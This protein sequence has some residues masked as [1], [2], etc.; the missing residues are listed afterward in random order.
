[1]EVAYLLAGEEL[2]PVV[3]GYPTALCAIGWMLGAPLA[4]NVEFL[5]A[6][7]FCEF[8][9]IEIRENFLHVNILES[10]GLILK[11]RTPAFQKFAKFYCMQIVCPSNSQKFPVANFS[12]STI[13]KIAFF[14]I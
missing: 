6:G 9:E 14:V 12:S 11:L 5:H 3:Y 13:I 1:M 10:E 2:F 7:N 4:G 8:R